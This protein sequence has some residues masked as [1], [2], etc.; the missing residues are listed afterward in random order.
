MEPVQTVA[1]FQN[2]KSI[3][4]TSE[5]GCQFTDPIIYVVS[6]KSQQTESSATQLDQGVQ[7]YLNARSADIAT[8]TDDLTMTK[9]ELSPT[10]IELHGTLPTGSISTPES[11]A[12]N[13]SGDCRQNTSSLN[14]LR[15]HFILTTSEEILPE[16]VYRSY[17]PEEQANDSSRVQH[18]SISSSTPPQKSAPPNEEFKDWIIT[19]SEEMLPEINETIMHQQFAPSVLITQGTLLASEPNLSAYSSTEKFITQADTKIDQPPISVEREST[20]LIKYSKEM[21]SEPITAQHLTPKEALI[22]IDHSVDLTLN[23]EKALKKDVLLNT[24]QKPLNDTLGMLVLTTEMLAKIH[25][26]LDQLKMM[27]N[28]SIA[29]ESINVNYVEPSLPASTKRQ[30]QLKTEKSIKLTAV[31]DS[32]IS[33]EALKA[34]NASI[35]QPDKAPNMQELVDPLT[36]NTDLPLK[37]TPVMLAN[38]QE[39]KGESKASHLEINLSINPQD[40]ILESKSNQTLPLKVSQSS[41]TQDMPQ[42]NELASDR[43]ISEEYPLSDSYKWP[44]ELE[45][46]EKPKQ[47][48]TAIKKPLKHDYRSITLDSSQRS[49]PFTDTQSAIFKKIKKF[50]RIVQPTDQLMRETSEDGRTDN[51]LETT[52]DSAKIVSASQESIPNNQSISKSGFTFLK[53][54]ENVNSPDIATLTAAAQP[55]TAALPRW[56]HQRHVIAASHF[57]IKQFKC[58][59]AYQCSPLQ[60][61]APDFYEQWKQFH[62][63]VASQANSTI[64]VAAIKRRLKT[65]LRCV[66]KQYLYQPA[67]CM[68]AVGKCQLQQL[69]TKEELQQYETLRWQHRDRGLAVELS[70]EDRLRDALHALL[71]YECQ[72]LRASALGPRLMLRSPHHQQNISE[73]YLLL[74]L[75]E[76]GY[77]YRCLQQQQ[78]QLQQLCECGRALMP[79]LIV[80]LHEYSRFYQRQMEQPTSLIQLFYQT[81]CYVHRFQWLLQLCG[82]L[83]RQQSPLL[84]LQHQLGIGSADY[85]MLLKNWLQAAAAPLLTRIRNWLQLGVLPATEFFIVEHAECPVERYWLQQFEL[86]PQQLPH[87]LS[88]Q[89]AQQLCSAGRN[90]HFARQFLGSQLRLVVPATE[91]EQQLTAACVSSFRELDAQPLGELMGTLQLD[92]SRQLFRQL[93]QLHPSPL[94]LLSRLHQ[95]LLLTDVEFVREMIELLEPALEQPVECYSTRQLNNM[96]DQLLC[97]FNKSLYVVKGDQQGTHCWCCFLLRWHQP[98]HWKALLGERLG[99]YESGFACLWQLHYADY[100]LNERIRRQQ[101]H[102][103]ER[104]NLWQSPEARQV[105]DRF[106]QFIDRLQDF[107]LKLRCYMLENVLD[108][109]YEDLSL[110]YSAVK[111]LDELLQRHGLYMDRILKGLLLSSDYSRLRLLLMRLYELIFQLDVMQQKFLSNCQVFSAVDMSQRLLEQRSYCQS[112]CHAIHDLEQDF[113]LVLANLLLGLY[114]TNEAQFCALAKKLDQSGYYEHRYKELKIVHTFRYQRKF[115]IP[116]NS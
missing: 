54:S 73:S 2:S 116:K 87:F 86:L 111:T 108:S 67:Q 91:L 34:D 44:T 32:P 56:Q 68:A 18:K 70:P 20:P 11:I 63:I 49:E 84:Y 23:T 50:I 37:G 69:L 4:E 106:D 60:P 77:Y 81:R 28:R 53:V 97:A 93:Q 17:I 80:E 61:D 9:A 100:V 114:N 92:T 109:A 29:E 74:A 113:Q 36:S 65:Y 1:I 103:W 3:N 33:H 76:V 15:Q 31:A 40:L 107:M 104:I 19:E 14:R 41:M 47:T 79:C 99:Q 55:A 39:T 101:S 51:Q 12:T 85:D 13:Y 66:R 94:E 52:E 59:P 62:E 10:S 5:V 25:S 24:E 71:G 43:Q 82:G 48:L 102:F 57:I 88:M 8:T 35:T 27:P 64:N 75:A 30:Q 26:Q 42:D 95:Y 22:P 90:Q 38:S 89:L 110:G 96:L 83:S 16:I 21:I 98:N 72:Q 105:R 46:E 45:T 6:N 115:K 58:N 112:T 78:E 7:T